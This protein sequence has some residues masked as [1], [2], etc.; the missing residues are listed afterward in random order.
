[1]GDLSAPFV[2][3]LRAHRFAPLHRP[4]VDGACSSPSNAIPGRIILSAVAYPL[5]KRLPNVDACPWLAARLHRVG[6]GASAARRAAEATSAWLGCRRHAEMPARSSGLP[7]NAFAARSG[8]LYHE[9]TG[10]IGLALRQRG[11]C[12]A[13]TNA[14]DTHPR[15]SRH[16]G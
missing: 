12:A 9:G 1:V 7:T 14:T 13:W 15:R 16:L 8:P 5:V 4:G 3:F 10:S 6:H 11:S 2:A